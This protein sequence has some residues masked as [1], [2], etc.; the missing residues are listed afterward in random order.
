[1]RCLVALF[2]LAKLDILRAA[3]GHWQRQKDI[4]DVISLLPALQGHALPSKQCRHRSAIPF[5]KI[6]TTCEV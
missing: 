1:M 4:F 3:K 2:F 6:V 5:T